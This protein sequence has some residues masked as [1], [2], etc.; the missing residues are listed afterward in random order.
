MPRED[1]QRLLKNDGD[2]LVRQSKD[3]KTGQMQYVLSA[4]CKGHKHFIIQ[5][6]KVINAS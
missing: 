1:V 6:S 3:K 2:F 4:Y 5:G